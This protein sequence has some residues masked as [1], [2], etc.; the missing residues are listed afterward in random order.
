MK[1][2]KRPCAECPWRTDAEPGRFEEERWEA[3]AASSPDERGMGPEH[4]APLFAC[5]RTPEGGERAC[6]GWLATV[7]RAHP[8]VRLS[9]LTGS[10]PASALD[11]KGDWPSLHPDFTTT[12]RHDEAGRD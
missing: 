4:D 8:M 6:A 12:R 1:H 2:V 3:L 9:V 11:S 7:G 5:H 10:L